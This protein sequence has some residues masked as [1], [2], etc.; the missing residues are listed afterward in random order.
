MAE[1]NTA[2]HVEELR[3]RIRLLAGDRR[4][5]MDALGSSKSANAGVITSLTESNAEM[6]KRLSALQC[7]D[8]EGDLQRMAQ[9]KAKLRKSLDGLRESVKSKTKAL[10]R[11]E[12]AMAELEL[13]SPSPPAVTRT[14]RLLENRLDKALIKYNEAQSIRKTYEQI[15]SRLREERVG[16]DHHLA[17]LERS[18]KTKCRD[19][20]ELVLLS[21]DA[22]HA[23]D[24]A[25]TELEHVRAGYDEERRRRGREL[26]DRHHVIQLRKQAIEQRQ[27]KTAELL[28]T[29]N[30]Q[31][32]LQ[33]ESA[34]DEDGS[35]MLVEKKSSSLSKQRAEQWSKIDIFEAAFRKI[36]EATGVSEVNEVI[37]KIVSQETTTKNLMSL[38][39]ENVKKIQALNDLKTRIKA[40]VEDV[41]Y[42]APGG[43]HRRK[44]V[45]ESE[46]KLAAA[47]ARIDRNAAKYERSAKILVAT[48]AG[49]KHL[50]DKLTG[51]CEQVGR[52][53]K[54]SPQLSDDTV[55]KL[56][57]EIEELMVELVDRTRVA[58]REA[59]ERASVDEAVDTFQQEHPARPYNQRIELP[60]LDG[61]DDAML[62]EDDILNN[63]L[64]DEITRDKVKRASFQVLAAQEKLRKKQHHAAHKRKMS[65]AQ[66]STR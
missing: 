46:E 31:Q 34:A 15:V 10:K 51:F 16:F 62:N 58:R 7:R 20:E 56:V 37:K 44:L 11:N 30:Q 61:C 1:K 42:A 26:K 50:Q 21:G 49:A 55:V 24:L 22:N 9:E 4:A 43:G 14:I 23:K 59:G 66:Q 25:Q 48:K 47:T 6:R 33:P 29:S 13:E 57:G 52:G 27:Q 53:T 18:Y 19:L 54:F 64:E 3:R 40:H 2:Q 45:D 63:D 38:T 39:N 36:K 35:L 17:V 12:D 28:S 60:F 32:Q 41:K 65:S 8:G 5:H